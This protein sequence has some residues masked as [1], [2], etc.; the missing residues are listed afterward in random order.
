MIPERSFISPDTGPFASELNALARR[1][2]ARP[3]VKTDACR[4]L[5]EQ[6]P[7]IEPTFLDLNRDSV[8]IGR[9]SDLSETQRSDL[10]K[11]LL[12]LKPWRKGPFDLFGIRVDGEWNS[13]LK[14]R[15]VAPHLAPLGDRRVL[16]VGSSNGYYLFRMAAAKPRL[17]LGIEPYRLYFF[18]FLALQ[19]FASVP[20][21]YTLPLKLEALPAMPRWFDTIFCMGVLYHH[22]SPVDTLSQ[23]GKMLAGGGQ[24]ILETLIIRGDSPHALFPCERY[25]RMRNVYFLPTVS[26]LENWLARSGFADV[27]CVDITATTQ[28]EQRKTRWIDSESLDSSLDPYDSRLTVEGYPAPVRAVVLATRN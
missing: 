26:C 22:R 7:E 13:A 17:I 9:S 1:E 23:L 14:W 5:L 15:R 6:L 3:D 10:E 24:L 4:G 18:Q 20:C 21:I 11:V 16:D 28:R 27:N 19:R 25:A 2:L 12:G 8:T